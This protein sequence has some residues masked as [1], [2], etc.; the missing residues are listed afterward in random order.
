MRLHLLGVNGPYP[1]S[2]GANSGYLLEAGD[3]LFQFDFG[4]GVLARLTALAPPESLRAILGFLARFSA[5]YGTIRLPL[6]RNIELLSLIRSPLAYDIR[7]T[8]EQS[9][10]IRVINVV[11]ALEAMR[12]PAGCDFV[13]RVTDEMIPENN[14]TWKVTADAVSQTKED[15]DLTV[16]EKALG[17]LVSGAISLEEALYRDDTVVI[18]HRE[19]LEKIFIR[20]PILSED[21]F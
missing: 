12:K 3:A 17:Q 11:R 10:M 1:Q 16:S 15:P 21:P 5:D 20:K 6:P 4:A 14:G 8:T 7:T 19:A 18:K 2:N 13:I 9:Y